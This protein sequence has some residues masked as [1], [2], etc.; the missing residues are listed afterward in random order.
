M[1]ITLRPRGP[2]SLTA[3]AIYIEGF[4]GT[5]A[6]R[7]PAALRYA[8]AADGDWHT[9]QATLRQDKETV[10]IE[11]AGRPATQLR[12]RAARDLEQMLCLDVDGTGF[13]ANG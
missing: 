9:V 4:P 5:Q 12:Q 2:F 8:W 6:D 3:A 7:T 1:T 10:H 13:V 11:L